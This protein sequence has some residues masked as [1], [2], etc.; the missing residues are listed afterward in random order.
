MPKK[1]YNVKLNWF[2]EV[3]EFFTKADSSNAALY[4]ATWRLA[5]ITGCSVT[6]VRKKIFDGSDSY[7][8][9]ERS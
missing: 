2:G 1:S 8:V 6:Y 5:Y 9:I 7:K 3:H 4:N